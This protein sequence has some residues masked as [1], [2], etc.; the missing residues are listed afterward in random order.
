VTISWPA[1]RLYQELVEQGRISETVAP[2]ST[3]E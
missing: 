1:Q 3:S 2:D